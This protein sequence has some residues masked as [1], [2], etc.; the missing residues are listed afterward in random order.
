MFRLKSAFNWRTAVF[1]RPISA[2]TATDRRPAPGK[3]AHVPS[4]FCTAM[5]L[6]SRKEDASWMNSVAQEPRHQAVVGPVTWLQQSSYCWSYFM[7][8]SAAVRDPQKR[9]PLLTVR[10]L[11]RSLTKQRQPNLW[12]LRRTNKPTITHQAIIKGGRSFALAFAVFAPL[13][14]TE[15]HSC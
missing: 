11:R 13:F 1:G 15:A 6:P 4:V 5:M 8:F 7:R 14:P 3:S 9:Q 10:R 2:E 12:H